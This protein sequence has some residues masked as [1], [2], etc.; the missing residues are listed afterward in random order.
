MTPA[1]F[2]GGHDDSRGFRRHDRRTHVEVGGARSQR[3]RAPG[4]ARARRRR[5][6]PWEEPARRWGRAAAALNASDAGGIPRGYDDSRGFR[7]RDRSTH[8]DVGVA[9]LH[10]NNNN[11]HHNKQQQQTQQQQT[12]TT[13]TTPTTAQFGGV[14]ITTRTPTSRSEHARR[15]RRRTIGTTTRARH[16]VRAPPSC[17]LPGKLVPVLVLAPV[18]V[19][20]LVLV[21]VRV[22]ALGLCG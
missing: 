1:E 18:M 20:V 2:C 10:N 4:S 17:C 9:R 7:R 11:H 5:V 21:L 13:T 19:L 16:D 6:G 22:L 15:G 12:T 8:D 3:R 14:V